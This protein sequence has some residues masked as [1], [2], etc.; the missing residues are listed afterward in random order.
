MW[1]RFSDRNNKKSTLATHGLAAMVAGFFRRYKQVV[2]FH[3]TGDSTDP[4]AYKKFVIDLIRAA[5]N[6]GKL[7]IDS[8]IVDGGPANVSLWNE[9]GFKI[10]KNKIVFK[11]PHP[12]DKDRFLW[13]LVDPI[14]SFKNLINAFRNHKIVKIP[15]YFVEKYKLKSNT[16]CLND[17]KS[18]LVLQESM[19]YKVA[20][21]LKERHINPS[22]F[23]TMR[24][25][26]ATALV[27]QDV[28]S[29]LHYIDQ[30]DENEK[31][32]F[33]QCGDFE[34]AN[35]T[36]WFLDYLKKWFDIIRNRSA[37]KAFC[38]ENPQKIQDDFN[39]LMEAIEFFKN[40][41]FGAQGKFVKCQAFAISSS[42]C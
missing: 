24:V 30:L 31:E 8:I 34:N 11:I 29:A 27:S 6:N 42:L 12:N 2:G 20:P 9:M 36:A 3:L 38:I 7:V 25:G 4:I 15:E 21:R 32:V 33:C 37:E 1:N 41:R 19:T 39:F 14:H 28:R 13:L 22:H 17:I 5:E 16:A 18:L 10:T 23:D 40:I 26:N 35:T